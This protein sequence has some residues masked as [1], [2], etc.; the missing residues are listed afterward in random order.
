MD[1]TVKK[2]KKR[3]VLWYYHE[4]IYLQ[5]FANSRSCINKPIYDVDYVNHFF[6]S[7]AAMKILEVLKLM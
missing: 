1:K 6:N 2:W 4:Y 5:F 7:S 3:E